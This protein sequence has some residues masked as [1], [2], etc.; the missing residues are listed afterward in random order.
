[1]MPGC[2]ICLR[3]PVVVTQGSGK[4][5][6]EA[7]HNGTCKS[8]VLSPVIPELSISSIVSVSACPLRLYYDQRQK[9]HETPRYTIAKQISY[10]LG[11]AADPA[12][13][14]GEVCHVQ[15][16]SDPAMRDFF[17]DCFRVCRRNPAWRSPRD[18]DLPVR[19]AAYHIHGIVDKIFDGEP[20]FSIVRSTKAPETG[21]YQSDRIR[22]AA[23]AA[24]LEEMLGTPVEGG[25]VEYI[26]S[27]ISRFC[28]V[29]PIDKR[30]FLRALHE[31]RR[32]SS[33]ELPR[34]PLRPPC[35]HCSHNGHCVPGGGTRLSDI[36]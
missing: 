19:S 12:E 24:C 7:I 16:E 10:H 6:A 2:A 28:R 30:R 8:P 4:P 3:G 20:V 22:I 14:W 18:T 33:G 17:E 32:I 23:Y 35:E 31:A 5:E 15:G 34:K 1:M 11:T 25:D 36:L 29:A 27:G 21:V 26:P 9:L 13:V